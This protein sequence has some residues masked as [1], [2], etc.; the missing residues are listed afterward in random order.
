MFRKAYLWLVALVVAALGAAGFAVLS[1]ATAA[2][3]RAAAAISAS[4]P[5]GWYIDANGGPHLLPHG[6]DQAGGNA[7]YGQLGY[8]FR[9]F[10]LDPVAAPV[11]STP[12]T[13]AK[14]TLNADFQDGSLS[15]RT[16][17]ISGL[18]AY[19]ASSLE[20]VG[21]N[22]TGVGNLLAYGLTTTITNASP[23]G[24]ELPV[25]VVVQIRPVTPTVGSTS[26]RFEVTTTGFTG[27]KSFVLD[28]WATS[29][30]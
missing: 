29:L 17:T 27:T 2:P 14:V 10:T 22:I 12:A 11:T 4:A 3:V 30:T 5:R 7:D 26:R 1:P 16:V 23:G 20:Q 13:H 9:G 24:D 28:L 25:I 19:R 21:S 15:E 6:V 18:P 8:W